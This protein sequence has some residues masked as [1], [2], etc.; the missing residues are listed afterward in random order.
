MIAGS[1]PA[2]FNPFQRMN[3]LPAIL[4]LVLL[5]LAMGAADFFLP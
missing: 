2:R 5:A 1:T 3:R 4:I